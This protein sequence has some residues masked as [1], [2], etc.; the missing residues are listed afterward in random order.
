[1]LAVC[2]NNRSLKLKNY[3]GIQDN[4]LTGQN[5]LYFYNMFAHRV[6][7]PNAMYKLACAS[8]LYDLNAIWLSCLN[9][10]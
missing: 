6:K 3:I 7:F 2:C 1:M 5:A 10:I 8:V 9:N 4:C